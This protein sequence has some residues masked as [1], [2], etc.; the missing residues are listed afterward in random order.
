MEPMKTG[1]QWA[2]QHGIVIQDPDGWRYNDG[3]CLDTYITEED[4]WLRA[5]QCTISLLAESLEQETN[6]AATVAE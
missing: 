1:R 6:T 2:K 4:F 3:V 5:M